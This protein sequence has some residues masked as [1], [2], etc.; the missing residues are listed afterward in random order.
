M[1]LGWYVT[2]VGRQH[3]DA[4][5]LDSA[6]TFH[7]WNGSGSD[8]YIIGKKPGGVKKIPSGNSHYL[9]EGNSISLP[10]RG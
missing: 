1:M 9:K 7:G 10:V 4:I 5:G 2:T 3:S 8:F 6:L